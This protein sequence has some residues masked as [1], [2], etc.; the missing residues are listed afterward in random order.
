MTMG[1]DKN[2]DNAGLQGANRRRYERVAFF[3]P[4]HVTSLQGG[5]AVPARSFD[6]SMGGVGLT[7]P[8][9]LERGETVCVRFHLNRASGEAVDEDVW[10]RV[11]Y[12]RADEDGN[13]VGIEFI[14]TLRE[15]TQPA[16]TRRIGNL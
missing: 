6:I 3:C 1:N 14:N 9:S 13:R 7:A 5:A 8:I 2:D 10:G 11:A 15:A 12:S 16:L 4:L